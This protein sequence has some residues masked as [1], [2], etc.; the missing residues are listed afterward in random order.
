MFPG[1]AH[2]VANSGFGIFSP[3]GLNVGELHV[4]E[5]SVEAG[6]EGHQE[7]LLTLYPEVVVCVVE[8]PSIGATLSEHEEI[9]ST[10]NEA[11]GYE[12]SEED[13][14]MSASHTEMFVV[15]TDLLG[16]PQL[17]I[18]ADFVDDSE[19]NGF[20]GF[21]K[22]VYVGSLSGSLDGGCLGSCVCDFLFEGFEIGSVAFG[23]L[24]EG[25][26]GDG[27]GGGKGEARDI[28][29]YHLDSNIKLNIFFNS[30]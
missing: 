22:R 1:D 2:E 15:G 26:L 24:R 23:E 6:Q 10:G 29:A 7:I 11:Q 13:K 19:E 25:P 9:L 28:F 3:V 14:S 12:S 20:V 16:T 8:S 30:G 5:F 27:F 21:V 18:S 17:R 4:H